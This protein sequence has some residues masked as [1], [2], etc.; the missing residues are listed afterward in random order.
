MTYADFVQSRVKFGGSIVASMTA[1][2]A[3]MW[4]MVTGIS[5]E[6]GELLDAV[7]KAV[8]Y[9]KPLDVENVREEIGDILFYVQGLCASLGYSITQAMTDNQAKLTERYPTEY[10]D[11]AAQERSDKI[12]AK[13]H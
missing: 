1:D 12:N 8:I 4:H 2:D 13:D 5:G 3:H 9:R 10:T 6:S 7:K 11:Q